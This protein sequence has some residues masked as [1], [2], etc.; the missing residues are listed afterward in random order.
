MKN[1]QFQIYELKPVPEDIRWMVRNYDQLMDRSNRHNKNQGRRT[2]GLI[3]H[4]QVGIHGKSFVVDDAVAWI[5]SHNFDPRSDHY[6]TEAALVIWDQSV[7]GR[8]KNSILMDVAPQNSY[9]IAR[10]PQVPIISYFSGLLGSLSRALPFL[11]IWPFR[12][13][14]SHELRDGEKPVSRD[15]PQFD[16]HYKNMGAF[17]GINL[18][19]RAMQ[20]RLLTALGGFAAPIL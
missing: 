8:L 15:H 10:Q 1:L 3:V 14:T 17:P 12:Y 5:G 19:I 4:P 6:N 9:F 7:A 18:S 11:D 2:S 16:R 13:T 20:A